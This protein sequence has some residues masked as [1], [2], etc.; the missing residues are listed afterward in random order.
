MMWL[1]LLGGALAFGI[2]SALL[3]RGNRALVIAG[4]GPPFVLLVALLYTE[5]F[6]PYQGGGASMWPIALVVAGVPAGTAALLAAVM[7][8]AVRGRRQ[9]DQERS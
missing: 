4:I 9:G 3:M 8:Q 7:V 2:V 1:L 6:V 5:Y